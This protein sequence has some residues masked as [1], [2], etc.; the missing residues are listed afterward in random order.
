MGE[1]FAEKDDD[2]AF[3]HTMV[4]MRRGPLLF[5]SISRARY[6]DIT[7]IDL[8][9]LEI[10]PIPRTHVYPLL[11]TRAP[12]PLPPDVFLKR[13]GLDMYGNSKCLTTISALFMHEAQMCEVIK[14][15]P[16]PNVVKYF[17]CLLDEDGRISELCFARYGKTLH[18]MIDDGDIFDRKAC[19]DDIRAGIEHIHSLGMIHCDINP[20]NVFADVKGF[21]IGDF[22]SCALEGDELG[23]KAGTDGWTSD[24]FVL[25]QRENDWFGFAKIEQFLFPPKEV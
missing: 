3:S 10:L 16:H 8:T 25:A 1:G 24:D 11:P 21:V 5:Y 4:I 7:Q 23:E 6:M 18:Q 12:N 14:R 19:L 13:P 2:I 9:K 20:R 15:S 17:G 22:D